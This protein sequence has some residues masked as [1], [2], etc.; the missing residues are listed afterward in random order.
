VRIINDQGQS[1]TLKVTAT[2]KSGTAG[3]GEVTLTAS[4]GLFEN[5]AKVNTL[6]L[7]K[8]Q[9]SATF[10]CPVAQDRNCTGLVTVQATWG[11]ETGTVVLQVVTGS[12]NGNTDAGTG[13]T[14][15]GTG[16]TDAG[17]TTPVGQPAN[18][19]ALQA[20]I[21]K[22]LGI[23][24]SNLQTST[25]ISFQVVDIAKQGVPNVTVNFELRG[26]GGTAL[27][28]S[29]AT[30]NG[31]G[32]A[33]TTLQAGDEVGFAIVRATVA[34]NTV[35]VTSANVLIGGARP[36]DEG[37]VVNCDKTNL[38]ANASETP[39]RT[40]LSTPCTAQLVDRFSNPVT[41]DTSVSWYTEAGSVESPVSNG[42]ASTDGKVTTH[43]QTAGRWPPVEVSALAGEPQNGA[44]SPRDM[45]VTVIAV[46]TGEETFYDGSGVS[47]GTKNGKWDPGEWFVDLPEP[48]VDANDNGLYD[49]GERF[50]D[51]DRVDCATGQRL[52]KNGLWDGPNGCWGGETQIWHS[53]HIIYS[54]FS[55]LADAVVTWDTDATN[56]NVPKG[57]AKLPNV[58]I[59]DAYRNP[60]APEAATVTVK[61]SPKKGT[62]EV[63][64]V[65]P[66]LQKRHFGMTIT[67]ELREVAPSAS[68]PGYMDVG[69]CSEGKAVDQ[70]VAAQAR[71]MWR[72]VIS[73]YTKGNLV[74]LNVTGAP[75]DDATPAQ[76]GLIRLTIE[77]AYSGLDTGH[78]ITIQ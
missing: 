40:D 53:T 13:N 36:S 35:L 61:M 32:M 50:I 14:D 19:L 9:A 51:T 11:T 62:L 3:T 49:L 21:P 42:A 44:R 24:S 60:I 78:A 33:T 48:F 23:R 46:T 59:S 66:E 41:L 27:L 72:Y 6:A 75:A 74:T 17:T 26:V 65:Y 37:F 8:G 55:T 28:V 43:F 45:L 57:G 70:A 4:A 12:G 22:K 38:A 69:A 58:L 31:S 29:S 54:G 39:P 16:N 1:S 68:A 67:H 77:D 15:A 10:R 47:K 18:I 5:D 71:C 76:S 73:N 25:P 30:T 34:N 63:F 52:A 64:D 20:D 7:D 56:Y 2:D